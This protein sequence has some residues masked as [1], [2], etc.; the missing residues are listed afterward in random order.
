[1]NYKTINLNRGKCVNC[2]NTEFIVDIQKEE[3]YCSRCGLIMKDN[4]IFSLSKYIQ[5]YNIKRLHQIKKRK[6]SRK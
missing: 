3:Q 2:G 5:L 4:S 1:M 6:K